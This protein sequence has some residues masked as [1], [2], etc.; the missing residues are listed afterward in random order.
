MK[1]DAIII[2]GGP[3]GSTAATYLARAG[4]K[5]L[6]LEKEHFP[7]FHIGESLLPYN[8]GIFEELGVSDKLASAGFHKKYGAQFHLSNSSKTLKLCFRKGKYTR[9]IMSL[10]VERSKFDHL[11]LNHSRESGAEVR[12]GWTVTK[13]TND[14]QQIT[15]TARDESGK[16]ETFEAHFLIDASGRGNFTGNQENL[17]EIHPHLKKISLFGHF[18]GVRFDEGESRGDTCVIRFEN[19]WFWL[20]PLT[21][22][23]GSVGVV[24]EQEE[25]IKA[26][27]TPTELFERIWKS[28]S[29]MRHRMENA[30]PLM[31]IQATGDF[32][33]YNRKL[34][35]PRLLRIGDAAGFL[36]PIFSTGVFLAMYSAR[37]AALIVDKA[38]ATGNDGSKALIKYEKKIFKALN[39]YWEMVEG[40]YTRPFMEIFVQPQPRDRARLVDAI[41][42]LLAGELEGG[43]KIEWRRWLFFILV[44]IHARRPIV[45]PLSFADD[46][47]PAEAV[48]AT[49]ARQISL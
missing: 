33:Y 1:Y 12:E 17:R 27:Q 45:P 47:M 15:V 18:E 5:V 7:R 34:I 49:N 11:L 38:L 3:G 39:Y 44:K 9:H 46:A 23:K 31:D 13:S 36:D 24:M 19:K 29:H 2:G 25:F 14:Q 20:I 30:R 41:V 40:F 42:A 48:C 43:W 8:N 37:M 35:G 4:R 21:E 26:R 10:Q 16:V 22:S 32:S 6:L 28:S